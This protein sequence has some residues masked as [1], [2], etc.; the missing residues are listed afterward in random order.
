MKR[1]EL[2]ATLLVKMDF[3]DIEVTSRSKDGSIDVRGTLLWETLSAL[4][5]PFR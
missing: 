3:E 4:A 2:I 5:W 1:Q